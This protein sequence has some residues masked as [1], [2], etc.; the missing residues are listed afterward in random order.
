MSWYITECNEN[1]YRFIVLWHMTV[2][3]PPSSGSVINPSIYV[4]LESERQ[5]DDYSQNLVQ[6]MVGTLDALLGGRG[7]TSYC[8][9][10]AVA[11]RMSNFATPIHSLYSQYIFNIHK[12]Q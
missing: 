12:C 7:D 6:I 8:F 2:V 1:G 9:E 11:P 5:A 10:V 3:F 4:L